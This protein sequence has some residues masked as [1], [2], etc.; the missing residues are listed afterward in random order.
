MKTVE[1]DLY[2]Q[3][4][5]ERVW[6]LFTDHEGYTFFKGASEAKL[7]QEGSS[8]KNGVG[9]VRRFRILGIT[10]LED[11]VT[12]DPPRHFEYHLTECTLPIRHEIGGAEFTPRDEGTDV[13]WSSR[14]EVSIPLV[15]KI[16]AP[17]FY[18]V[19]GKW[20]LYVLKQAKAKLEA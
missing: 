1:A 8:D 2:I 14:F 6:E 4:P 3:A 16:L 13:H 20:L 9:A 10:F 12:F 5:I 11:I 19:Y 18:R 7:L 17:I 15:G